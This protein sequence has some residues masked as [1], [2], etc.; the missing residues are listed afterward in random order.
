MAEPKQNLGEEAWCGLR[1]ECVNRLPA[2]IH[3]PQ[4]DAPANPSF[5]TQAQAT[6]DPFAVENSSAEPDISS[7]QI[8]CEVSPIIVMTN[9]KA[10][11]ITASKCH[12]EELSRS[13]APDPE[14]WFKVKLDVAPPSTSLI[15]TQV[16]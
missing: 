8:P 10:R 4:R 2:D 14:G 9:G 12:I 3:S 7:H 5:V 16:P 1:G 6:S 13:N 15:A 11:Q